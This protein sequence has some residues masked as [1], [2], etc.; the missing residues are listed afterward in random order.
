MGVVREW[1]VFNY[2]SSAC[3]CDFVAFEVTGFNGWESEPGREEVAALYA[4]PKG[5]YCAL[6]WVM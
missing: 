3:V 4:H 5:Y 6:C 2:P 1:H